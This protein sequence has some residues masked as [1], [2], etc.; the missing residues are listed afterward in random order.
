MILVPMESFRPV[1][2]PFGTFNQIRPIGH[3]Q[4]GRNLPKIGVFTSLPCTADISKT[5]RHR[6]LI[7]VPMESS[8]PVDVPFGTFSQIRP[9]G[10]GQIGRNWPKIGVFTSLS[11]TGDISKTRRPRHLILVPMESSRPVY[12]PFGTFNQIRPVGHGQNCQKKLF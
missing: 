1:D 12:V 3:G 11:C 9:I 5:E 8:R 10:H 2:V 6:H 4:I 7:W